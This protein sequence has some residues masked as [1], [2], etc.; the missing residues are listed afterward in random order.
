M[1]MTIGEF[2]IVSFLI[3]VVMWL[4]LI[5]TKINRFHNWMADIKYKKKD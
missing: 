5:N 1:T 2:I 3:I 4:Q